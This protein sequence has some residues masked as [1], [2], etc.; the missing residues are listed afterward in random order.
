KDMYR[1]DKYRREA[2]YYLAIAYEGNGKT[3]EALECYKTIRANMENYRDI[4]A[5]MAAISG[6]SAG[7]A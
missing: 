1:M 4:Q 5:R 2:L 3:A 7:Q 6:E